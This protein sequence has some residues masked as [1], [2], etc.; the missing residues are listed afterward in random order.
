[1]RGP[2][3]KIAT[4]FYP[5]S[6]VFDNVHGFQKPYGMIAPRNIFGDVH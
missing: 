4:I 5:R 3:V 6:S 1:M 2:S